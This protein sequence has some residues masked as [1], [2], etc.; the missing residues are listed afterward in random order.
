M[1][2]GLDFFI[3]LLLIGQTSTKEHLDLLS[4][5]WLQIVPSSISRYNGEDLLQ[6]Q[7]MKTEYLYNLH[8]LC[9]FIILE[10]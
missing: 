7:L 2:L 4:S 8:D 1:E 5:L 9:V 3:L 10:L 6:G